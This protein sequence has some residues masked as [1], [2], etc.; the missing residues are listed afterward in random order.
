M[1]ELDS[2]RVLRA[3]SRHLD[4][5]TGTLV[6]EAVVR[7]RQKVVGLQERLERKHYMADLMWVSDNLLA[8]EIEVKV[9]RADWLADLTKGKWGKMPRWV[10]RFVYAVPAELGVPEWVPKDAGIWHVARLES[11]L[12]DV[13]VV[14]APRKLGGE[15]VPA[16]QLAL[17]KS[18]IY[19]KYWLRRLYEDHRLPVE[20][21]NVTPVSATPRS[22]RG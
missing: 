6:P 7:Y 4:W 16:H 21:S 11:R 1:I 18:N 19:Y 3:V 15:P 12:P 14:R 13:R 17:W 9:S 20:S 5:Q 10:S 8:T 2:E 22:A